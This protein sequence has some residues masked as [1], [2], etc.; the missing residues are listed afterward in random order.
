MFRRFMI[1]CWVLFAIP[2]IVSLVS[3]PMYY[4]YGIDL[5]ALFVEPEPPFDPEALID[6]DN[7]VEAAHLHD[8]CRI[9]IAGYAFRVHIERPASGPEDDLDD[10]TDEEF[11]ECYA[12]ARIT[13]TNE[14]P[15]QTDMLARR[16][17]HTLLDE[18][19]LSVLPQPELRLFVQTTLPQL[20]SAAENGPRPRASA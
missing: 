20:D 15:S 16:Q 13:T 3:W 12:A 4:K 9:D 2:A 8:G 17:V 1:V 7:S 14:A 11:A 19:R 5:D 10:L 18:I 6:D